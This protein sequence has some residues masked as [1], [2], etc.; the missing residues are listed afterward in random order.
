MKK[1]IVSLSTVLS[2]ALLSGCLGGNSDTKIEPKGFSQSL[3]TSGT[4]P[5]TIKTFSATSEVRYD[6]ILAGSGCDTS[7]YVLIDEPTS[8]NVVLHDNGFYTYKPDAGFLGSDI[9]S[10]KTDAN[11]S[12]EPTSITINI[13]KENATLP[14]APSELSITIDVSCPTN[15]KLSW[16]D[17]AD[18]ETG[19]VIYQDGKPVSITDCVDATEETINFTFEE[20]KTYTFEVRAKNSA[21][22]SAQVRKAV[23]LV[24]GVLVVQEV[25]EN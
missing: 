19:Y 10:Y 13:N 25:E 17:N 3:S 9:F 22:T 18:N 16:S 20:G 5:P 4:T 21:G 24:D 11:S 2:L 1:T 8:G 14:S 7:M 6:G 15:L 23:K 12:C